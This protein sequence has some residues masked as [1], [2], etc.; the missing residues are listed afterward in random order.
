MKKIK[1]N[2]GA[3]PIW[4]CDGW[5][6]LDHKLTENID[7]AI[8]G[9]AADINLPDESC[10]V[11]FC[12]HVFEHIPHIKLPLVLSEINRVL[13]KG[14]I[15]RLLT[16]DL[17]KIANAYVNKDQDF[18]DKFCQEDENI[19]TDLGFGGR[20]ANSFVSPG[21]DTV[22]LNRNLDQFIS[23]YAHLYNYDY[24]M[25][26]IL[27]SECG[28][29]SRKADFNDSVIPE[30]RTPL[31]VEGFEPVWQNFNRQ[32]YKDHNLVHELVDG[33]Y[34]INFKVTGFDRDPVSSLIVEASKDLFISKEV[35]NE[36]VN[37]STNNYNRYAYSLLS[38]DSFKEKLKSLGIKF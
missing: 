23:G 6:T 8:A 37:N 21:Q 19:R 38:D 34:N 10:E 27:L 17:E 13:V 35:I 4:S 22:L 32:F 15:L 31:H 30:L 28:F 9:D 12:S 29:K 24:E 33:V 16:P 3:S 14:G 1:L 26:S 20:F 7:N 5:H 25:M 2:L 36:K 11:V 18:W